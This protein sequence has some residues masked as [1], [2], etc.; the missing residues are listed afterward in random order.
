MVTGGQ[1][2]DNLFIHPTLIAPANSRMRLAREEIFGPVAAI[3]P[4][5]TEAEVI[6]LANATEYG[7]AA[8][9]YT[10]DLGRAF[11]VA[12]GLDYGMVGV[13][14]PVVS[15]ET[16]PFGGIKQSGF[17]REGGPHSLEDYT[18]LKYTLIGGLES[19]SK[20]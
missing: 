19:G 20:G 8:Y 14:E 12:E 15:S 7:L 6:K 5:R 17:G 11:R 4:F 1:K 3:F 9:F 13:N 16:I 10:K 18:V 2:P